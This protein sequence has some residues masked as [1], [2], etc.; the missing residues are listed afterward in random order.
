MY[1]DV[2]VTLFALKAMKR[3]SKGVVL[4]KALVCFT[5]IMKLILTLAL[6]QR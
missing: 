5:N 4:T 2:K 3:S 1:A 6:Q